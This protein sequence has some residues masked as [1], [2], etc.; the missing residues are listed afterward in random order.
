MVTSI[1]NDSYIHD[2]IKTPIGTPLPEAEVRKVLLKSPFIPIPDASNMRDIGL[3][4][5]SPIRPGLIFRSGALASLSASSVPLLHSELKLKAIFDIRVEHERNRHPDPDVDGVQNVWIRLERDQRRFR[6]DEFVED[7]G[8][9]G[10]LELYD[11]ILHLYA[12]L[13]KA[14]LEFLRDRP[15]EAVLFHCTGMY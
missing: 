12:P 1:E 3:V 2:L 11:E 6:P 7:G 8:V 14:L 13:Y 5:N 4:P 15:G 9:P 10:F